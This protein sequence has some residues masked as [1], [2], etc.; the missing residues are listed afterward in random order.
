MTVKNLH[1]SC[2]Q[3]SL[4]CSVLGYQAAQDSQNFMKYRRDDTTAIR[5]DTTASLDY[6]KNTL[7]GSDKEVLSLCL[8]CFLEEICPSGKAGEVWILFISK[9]KFLAV[10][11]S[12]SIESDI[13]L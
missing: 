1:R 2:G 11:L 10:T 12:I 6:L 5:D 13:S 4:K 3:S 8:Y 9:Y 7:A